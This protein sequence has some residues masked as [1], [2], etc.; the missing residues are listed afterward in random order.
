MSTAEEII[1]DKAFRRT[2]TKEQLEE[3]ER[4]IES[5]KEIPLKRKPVKA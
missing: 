5:G 4:F 1:K 2:K 3:L